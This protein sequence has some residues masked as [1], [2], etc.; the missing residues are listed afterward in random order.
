MR[1]RFSFQKPDEEIYTN[2]EPKIT[3]KE[4]ILSYEYDNG[5][6]QFASKTSNAKAA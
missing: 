6:L 3:Q 4:T 1:F 2:G 5:A